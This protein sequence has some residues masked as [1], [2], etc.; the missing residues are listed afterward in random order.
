MN[1]EIKLIVAIFLIIAGTLSAF[2]KV[3]QYRNDPE[4]A[5][6][7]DLLDLIIFF[8][9]QLIFSVILLLIGVGWLYYLLTSA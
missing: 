7:E 8:L 6:S 9:P 4:R 1:F 2:Q 5:L 3:R